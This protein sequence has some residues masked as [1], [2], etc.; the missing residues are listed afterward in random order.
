MKAATQVDY[1]SSVKQFFE[2]AFTGNPLSARIA[3]KETVV[4]SR[5]DYEKLGKAKRDPGIS[6][7]A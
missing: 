6:R 5:K 1:S 4:I 2:N 3:G 7:D